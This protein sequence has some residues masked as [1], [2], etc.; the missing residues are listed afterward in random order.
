[1]YVYFQIVEIKW[2]LHIC[3]PIVTVIYTRICRPFSPPIQLVIGVQ[4]HNLEMKGIFYGLFIIF[5]R[6][7]SRIVKVL[8]KVIFKEGG[9]FF[10]YT[11]VH[12]YEQR[13]FWVPFTQ[14]VPGILR[15]LFR[16]IYTYTY[17]IVCVCF[18]IGVIR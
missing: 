16:F 7:S 14:M 18:R 11:H 12:A 9:N 15:V 8:K 10:T 3:T 6:N 17:V 2:G 13:S 4:F 5:I 1:M